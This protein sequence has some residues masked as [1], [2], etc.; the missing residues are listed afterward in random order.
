[1]TDPHSA[2]AIAQSLIRQNTIN[3][4][5]NEAIA[6]VYLGRILENA[7][8]QVIFYKVSDTRSCLAAELPGTSDDAPLVLSGHLD[9]VPLG[10]TPWRSD[11]F[12]ADISDGKLYGRGSTDMKGGVGAI[13]AAAL[14][15]ARHPARRALK[16]LFTSGE[17][18]GCEGALHLSEI[19]A[20][21]RASAL[22]IAEPTSNQPLI[23]HRG[24]LWLELSVKGRAA[25]GSMPELGDNAVIGAARS[26][27]G[28][29]EFCDGMAPH[30]YLGAPTLS[31]GYFKGGANI[32]VV[33]DLAEFGIDIRT[34]PQQSHDKI[35]ADIQAG[36]AQV[37]IK[38]VA[39]LPPVFT[40][41]DE[42]W[43]ESVFSAVEHVTG[44]GHQPKTAPYF[45]DASIL[46]PAYDN[47]PI[48]ILGP[49]D[50]AQAHVCDEY[51]LVSRIE[52]AQSIFARVAAD[53]CAGH[54]P[55]MLSRTSPG[56]IGAGSMPTSKTRDAAKL[57]P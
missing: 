8:F 23:G 14:E 52:Q 34:I 30:P 3:P 46:G 5:G 18:T 43:I 37:H 29:E 15:V 13:V 22:L 49:G 35:C 7:G 45:T 36:H 10:E 39:D 25:H 56:D 16:L 48:V 4:P 12:G 1:M 28:L 51:C 42:P 31:V 19:A 57:D 21:G 47:P 38:R 2:V 26:I 41:A 40:P 9:T 33:P 11:P 17:E 27:I 32:N 50:M 55:Q 24:A 6:A 20:L 54:S 44:K 53:W